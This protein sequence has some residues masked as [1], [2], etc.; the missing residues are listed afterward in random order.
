[1]VA[2]EAA[3]V[4]DDALRRADVLIGTEAVLHRADTMV[5]GTM[6]GGSVRPRPGLVAFLEFD[7]ELLAPRARAAEQALWLLVRAASPRRPPSRPR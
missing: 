3:T 1:M 4:D 5:G 6:V 2:V 7:Q